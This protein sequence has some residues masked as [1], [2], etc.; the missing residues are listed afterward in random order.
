MP[1]LK[2]REEYA[3]AAYMELLASAMSAPTGAFFV[4]LMNDERRILMDPVEIK[5]LVQ[6]WERRGYKIVKNSWGEI[7]AV[8]G[9]RVVLL[10]KEE[11]A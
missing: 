11:A 4:C 6:R 3:R 9:E 7:F 8:R 1:K 5:L 10:A 2:Q